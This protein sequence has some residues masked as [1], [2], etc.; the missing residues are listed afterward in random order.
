MNFDAATRRRLFKPVNMKN[1]AKMVIM[2]LLTVSQLVYEKN[3]YGDKT[4]IHVPTES[5]CKYR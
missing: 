1:S 5:S 3:S 4:A 2:F